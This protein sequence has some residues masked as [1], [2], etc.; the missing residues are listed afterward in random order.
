MQL[1]TNGPKTKTYG[2]VELALVMTSIGL[3][4]IAG[5]FLG[6]ALRRLRK[7][8][9]QNTIF[10]E[11]KAVMLLHI[12]AVLVE[13]AILMVLVYYLDTL[14]IT[15]NARWPTKA[16]LAFTLSLIASQAVFIYLLIRF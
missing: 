2:D 12:I 8:F 14:I 15:P 16:R 3:A 7:S 13:Q 10:Q 9:Q 1:A 4:M 11:N 6:D 5:L